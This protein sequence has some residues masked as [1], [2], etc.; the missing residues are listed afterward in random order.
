MR[1]MIRV[2]PF[3]VLMAGAALQPA[4]AD[5]LAGLDTIPQDKLATLSGGA[6]P[7]DVQALT[8]SNSSQVDG[9]NKDNSIAID[10]AGAAMFNGGIAP[11]LVSGNSGVA[12]VMQN[13]G[14]LVN[15]NYNMSVNVYLQ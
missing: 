13:T 1:R 12:T 10:G 4:A 3:L 14:N 6:S 7:L 8:Q 5:A 15:M 2:A 9:S 11:A